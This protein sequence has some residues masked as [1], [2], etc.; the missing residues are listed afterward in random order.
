VKPLQATIT[1]EYADSKTAKAVTNAIAPDNLKAPI[2]IKINTVNDNCKVITNID[3]TGK[4]V[5]FIATIDDLLFS[6]IT[7]EKT[8]QTIK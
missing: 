1:L 2:D 7:A 3:C 6:T 4:I 8:L 5:T